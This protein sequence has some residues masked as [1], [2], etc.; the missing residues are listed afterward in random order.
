MIRR[1]PR[2]TLFPYTTLF[3]SKGLVGKLELRAVGRGQ[4]DSGGE[5]ESGNG[6]VHKFTGGFPGGSGA[7][8]LL[9]KWESKRLN[10]RH[11][12]KTYSGFC[13]Q[14]KKN[15]MPQFICLL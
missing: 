12:P 14:K 1:P 9:K 7:T 15:T 4:L 8:P 11:R 5:G 6:P 10:S 3:R 2:S 13:F